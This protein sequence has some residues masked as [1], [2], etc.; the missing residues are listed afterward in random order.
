V[1]FLWV[2]SSTGFSSG[3]WKKSYWIQA[4]ETVKG[5]FIDIEVAFLERVEQRLLW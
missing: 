1:T 4:Y 2:D 5:H 3:F